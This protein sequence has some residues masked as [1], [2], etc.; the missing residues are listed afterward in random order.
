V[1]RKPR[2]SPPDSLADPL[3][4][5]FENFS[6]VIKNPLKPL[7]AQRMVPS[8]PLQ[9][10]RSSL[11]RVGAVNLLALSLRNG[12]GIGLSSKIDWRSGGLRVPRFQNR[13]GQIN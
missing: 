5:P 8:S 13:D 4:P 10:S 12:S 7:A 3:I 11:K 1:G 6:H 2:K 9:Q